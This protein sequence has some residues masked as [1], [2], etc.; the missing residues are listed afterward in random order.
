MGYTNRWRSIW[1]GNMRT[2]WIVVPANLRWL[3]TV[4]PEIRCCPGKLRTTLTIYSNLWQLGGLLRE[5]FENFESCLGKLL[6]TWKV[7]PVNLD[8]LESCPG[9][10]W[11]LGTT[12][13]NSGKLSRQIPD[14]FRKASAYP[15]NA[16]SMFRILPKVDIKWS[17]NDGF[18]AYHH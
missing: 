5:T 3:W 18:G 12:F 8:N 4:V 16:I 6:T 14:N 10:H 1:L 2:F 9:K 17:E 15:R 7:V 13:D 11:Q